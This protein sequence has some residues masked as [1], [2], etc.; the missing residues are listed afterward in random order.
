MNEQRPLSQ[1]FCFYI[2]H[3]RMEDDEH[4]EQ[5]ERCVAAGFHAGLGQEEPELEEPITSH[6]LATTSDQS[7]GSGHS[8]VQDLIE[9]EAPDETTFSVDDYLHGESDD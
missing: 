6:G 4:G 7:T 9:T 1:P 3:T 5:A 8:Y 2:E